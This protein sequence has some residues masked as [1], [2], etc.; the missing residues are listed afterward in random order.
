MERRFHLDRQNAKFMGVCSGIAATTGWD[1]LLI[2][3]GAVAATVATGG[4]V[5]ILYVAAGLLAPAEA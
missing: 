2:R 4:F 1:P 5:P 3:L